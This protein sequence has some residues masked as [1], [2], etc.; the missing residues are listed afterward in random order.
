MPVN[1]WKEQ[2]NIEIEQPDINLK[3]YMLSGWIEELSKKNN[4]HFYSFSPIYLHF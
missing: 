3:T 2:K 1:I 4:T